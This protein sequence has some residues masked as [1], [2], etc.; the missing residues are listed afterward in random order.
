MANKHSGN[1]NHRL[2]S[3]MLLL[4][5]LSAACS[6]DDA[7]RL[8][9]QGESVEQ[10][11][12]MEIDVATPS[13]GIINILRASGNRVKVIAK[14]EAP[15]FAATGYRITINGTPA[16]LYE[17]EDGAATAQA[18]TSIS[19]D[20]KSVAGKEMPNGGGQ[21]FKTEKTIVVCSAADTAAATALESAIGK[22]F[23][24]SR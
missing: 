4:A 8:D 16:E 11:A 6:R 12:E 3:A 18:A 10:T 2:C 20:G 19:P 13:F 21:F 9:D 17:F 22:A 14:A 24:G 7:P 1:T 15:L 23:A 5:L